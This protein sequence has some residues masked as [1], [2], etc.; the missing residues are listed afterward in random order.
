[1]PITISGSTGI[2]GVDGSAS[3]PAVQG[4]D[5]N[6]GI[7]FPA[8]DTLAVATGGTERMRVDSSGNVGIGTSSPSEKLSVHSAIGIRGSNTS[9]T[10]YVGSSVN[11]SGVYTG[12]DGAGGFTTNVINS[13]YLN[14]ATNNTERMRIDSSGNVGIGTGSPAALLHIEKNVAGEIGQFIYNPN[15]GGYAA[16]RIGN[17]DR[18]TNGDHLIYGS[19]TLGVR[20]KTGAAITFEPAGTERMRLDTGGNL[21]FNSGYGSVATAYGCRAW[22]NFNGIGTVAIRAS[23]NVSSITDNSTGNY[24]VNFTTAMPDANY[25]AVASVSHYAAVSRL[26]L[27]NVDSPSTSAIALLTVYGDPWGH[28]DPNEVY[29]AIFR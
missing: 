26:T 17:S 24:T 22:V 1:M 3:T 6:T 19:S 13:G 7:A 28:Y 18:A 10:I 14:F 20:S 2:A 8:A 25:S 5:T 9:S 23:G 12:L 16:V 15:A 4:T 21:L 11:P 27:V 29:L